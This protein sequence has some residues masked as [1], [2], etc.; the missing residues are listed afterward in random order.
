M[1]TTEL[2]RQPRDPRPP[3]P[4]SDARTGSHTEPSF[5]DVLAE[6]VPLIGAVPVYGPPIILLAGPW[7]LLALVLAGPFALLLTFVAVL[8]AAAAVVALIAAVVAAPYLLV[9]RVRRYRTDH[10]SL[11]LSAPPLVTPESRWG[12][13]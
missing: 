8:V 3:E 10:A 11:R 6:T 1:T 2:I 7:L 9:R 13:A 12:A 5:G 4:G